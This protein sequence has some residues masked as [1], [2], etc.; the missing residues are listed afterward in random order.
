MMPVSEVFNAKLCHQTSGLH[1]SRVQTKT[2][3]CSPSAMYPTALVSPPIRTNCAY[4]GNPVILLLP[5]GQDWEARKSIN[6]TDYSDR[7]VTALKDLM[8]RNIAG[9]CC[10]VK[11][12][13]LQF[14][15][16]LENNANLQLVGLSDH[17]RQLIRT[18]YIDAKQIP[19]GM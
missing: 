12:R 5:C 8:S 9:H 14:A 4:E 18:Q 1:H 2:E 15:V 19:Q 3:F 7:A 6:R 10:A 16:L 11:F 17:K 13:R